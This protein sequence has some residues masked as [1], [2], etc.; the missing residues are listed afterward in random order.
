MRPVS[1]RFLD[2]LSLARWRPRVEYSLDAGRSWSPC[3]LVDGS[4]TADATSQVRW[5]SDLTLAGVPTGRNGLTPYGAR[6]RVWQGMW[7]SKTDVE[8]VPLGVYRVD[9]TSETGLKSGRV[10]VTGSS[11][12]QQVIDSRFLKPQSFVAQAAQFLLERLVKAAVPDASFQWLVEPDLIVPALIEERDRWNIIDGDAD[13]ASIAK[14]LAATVACDGRGVF[15]IAPVAS[16]T[17]TPVWSAVDAVAQPQRTLSRDG[18]YN[19]VVANGASTD[20]DTP[21]VG[22]GIAADM[23]PLSSTYA[24]GPFGK[25]ARF[26]SSPMLKTQYQC[27]E[28]AYSFLSQSL[29]LQQTVTIQTV[30]NFALEVGDVITAPSVDG[31]ME[32]NIIDSLE[33]PLTGGTMTPATRATRTKLAGQ[34]VTFE[35]LGDVDESGDDPA[36][37]PDE[38]DDDS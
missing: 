6:V 18:V 24:K 9:D 13:A 11:F 33:Y 8:E 15:V 21:P 35:D 10:Q 5:S 29:G 23:D 37:T 32:P 27:E 28:T 7:H 38:D 4:V 31:V 30:C 19:C 17:D 36:T 16:L 26:Y 3:T 14:A 2:G 1:D 34:I 22:P 20:E 25:V 12:E